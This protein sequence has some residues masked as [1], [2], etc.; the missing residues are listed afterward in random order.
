MGLA[1]AVIALVAIGTALYFADR[2]LQRRTVA[3]SA[4]LPA[5]VTIPLAMVVALGLDRGLAHWPVE[6]RIVAAA[7]V[8]GGTVLA[9]DWVRNR[10]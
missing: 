9:I 1:G 8:A 3:A 6:W 10:R 2:V 7:A 5:A 4:R